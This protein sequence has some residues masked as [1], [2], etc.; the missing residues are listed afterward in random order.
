MTATVTQ[1]HRPSRP[2]MPPMNVHAYVHAVLDAT[3]SLLR[4]D[5]EIVAFEA[6]VV[7]HRPVI[8]LKESPHLRRMVELGQASYDRT[9]SDDFGTYRIGVFE[10]CGVTVQWL[11]RV[12][13]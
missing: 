3:N 11:E 7:A 1:L 13:S 2:A 5:F 4:N 8:W 12:P 10:R 9:G 6:H